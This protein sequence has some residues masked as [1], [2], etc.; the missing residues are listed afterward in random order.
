MPQ[1]VPKLPADSAVGNPVFSYEEDALRGVIEQ[2][3][4]IEL[5]CVAAGLSYWEDIM[6]PARGFGAWG[7]GPLIA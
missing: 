2:E 4:Q 7:P 5:R 3:P 6:S 1:E